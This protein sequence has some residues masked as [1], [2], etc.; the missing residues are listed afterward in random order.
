LTTI[1]PVSDIIAAGVLLTAVV[2]LLN[3]RENRKATAKLNEVVIPKFDDVH[4]MVNS[5]LDTAVQRQQA[6]EA[7][8][9]QLRADADKSPAP[10]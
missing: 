1:D 2:G 10:E 7:E 9:V 3:N 4:A 8:N 5:Q 6:S